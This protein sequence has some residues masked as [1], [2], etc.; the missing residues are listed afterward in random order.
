VMIYPNIRGSTRYGKH[1]VELDNG[2]LRQD[3]IKDIG[4]LL[5]WIKTQAGLDPNRVLIRGHSY[6]GYV[7]LSVAANYSKHIS[8]AISF[9]G[10]SNLVTDLENTDISRRDRR[11]AEYGDEREPA[12]RE[13]LESIA[14]VHLADKVRK[15]LLIIQGKNDTRVPLSES[16]QM[17]VAAR[18]SG[19]SVWYLSASNEGHYF[20]N[21][22]TAHF[23][24]CTEAFF[25]T[26]IFAGS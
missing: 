3:A 13:F 9:A 7:A 17:V 22:R 8:G 26:T 25:A 2:R 10:P 20:A 11:R 5:D 12:T 16:M 18:R 6:G 19:T 14:P 1:Y 15:P 23:E 4:A 24:R 21:F